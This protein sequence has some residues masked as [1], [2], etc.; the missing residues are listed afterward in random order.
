MSQ[1]SSM[2]SCWSFATFGVTTFDATIRCRNVTDDF[3]ETRCDIRWNRDSVWSLH[4]SFFLW[5][6]IL[7]WRKRETFIKTNKENKAYDQF[8]ACKFQIISFYFLT[9]SD[10]RDTKKGRV[11]SERLNSI[12]LIDLVPFTSPN[13]LLWSNYLAL[14]DIQSRRLL[15]RLVMTTWLNWNH[16]QSKLTL[17]SSP[18][19]SS[20]TSLAFFA[21]PLFSRGQLAC[22]QLSR[23]TSSSRM[24]AEN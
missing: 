10:L 17:K 24:P 7:L 22:S 15:I 14:W 3:V 8:K 16:W 1:S 23:T 2:R 20:K 9:D 21:V 18:E 5:T 11:W 13:S 4:F 12:P 19:I 6:F